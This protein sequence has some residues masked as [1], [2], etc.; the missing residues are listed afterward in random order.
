MKNL[1]RGD[2]NASISSGDKNA[3]I[4]KW[5]SGLQIKSIE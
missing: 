2:K 1:S 4:G 3:S 5:A